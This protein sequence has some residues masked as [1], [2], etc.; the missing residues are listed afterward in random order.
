MEKENRF[1]LRL[2]LEIEAEDGRDVV[3]VVNHF[4]NTSNDVV[5]GVK[6]ISLMGMGIRTQEQ[7]FGSVLRTVQQFPIYAQ[8][9]E[10]SLE[11][12]AEEDTFENQLRSSLMSQAEDLTRYTSDQLCDLIRGLTRDKLYYWE[13]QGYIRPENAKSGKRNYRRYSSLEALKVVYIWRY[14]QAGFSVKNAVERASHE[15]GLLIN[16]SGN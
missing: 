7:H 6:K 1:Y 15:V 9:V 14:C 3:G 11:R 13:R 8:N 16:K 4:L 10:N 2:D 5:P 12:K